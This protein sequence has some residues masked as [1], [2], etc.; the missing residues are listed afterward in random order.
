MRDGRTAGLGAGGQR[1]GGRF[2]TL[3]ELAV[4]DTRDGAVVVQG[5]GTVAG[6]GLIAH[7]VGPIVPV[8]GRGWMGGGDE[9]KRNG[10]TAERM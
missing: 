3:P 9:E 4:V 2:E 1:T 8:I 6:F 10:Y 7:R 5:A